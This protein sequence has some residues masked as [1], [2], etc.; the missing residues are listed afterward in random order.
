MSSGSNIKGSVI[1]PES[2]V[3]E[4]PPEANSSSTAAAEGF[5]NVETEKLIR[6]L[7]L[8]LVPIL[9][10]LYLCGAC[11]IPMSLML[12]I[13]RLSFLDRSNIGNARLQGL[14][15]DLHMTG[16][17][18]NIALAVFFPCYIAVGVPS[19]MMMTRCRPNVWLTV[20]LLSWS[21]I[22]ICMGLVRNFTGLALV[23]CFL[24]IAEG[25][26]YPGATYYVTMWYPR[27]E[28]GLR[29]A[30]FFS[31]ATAAGAFGGLF[32]RG[33]SEMSGVGGKAGWSWIFIIEG[34]L[35]LCVASICYWA[36]SDYPDR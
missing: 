14:E 17:D 16:L 31:M 36:I 11:P 34:L 3:L 32:A 13:T 29:I 22:M 25:G 23:R 30:L 10:V 8:R 35:S 19:N 7:D 26:L 12:I 9:S 4:K 6:K 1:D 20:L 2:Y 18:Y 24:G 28:R 21:I 5:D 15:K 27:H 33:I